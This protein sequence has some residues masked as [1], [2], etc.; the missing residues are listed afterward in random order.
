[1]D[2]QLPT[3]GKG[4]PGDVPCSSAS[5]PVVAVRTPHIPTRDHKEVGC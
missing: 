1:M 3:D 2:E 4:T 5:P